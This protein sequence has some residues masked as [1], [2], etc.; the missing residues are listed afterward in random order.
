VIHVGHVAVP[1]MEIDILIRGPGQHAPE[2]FV[3]AMARG[4]MV[5]SAPDRM[6]MHPGIY[7]AA[8]TGQDDRKFEAGGFLATVRRVLVPGW[9]RQGP[10][11]PVCAGRYWVAG[12]GWRRGGRA[13]VCQVTMLEDVK[14]LLRERCEAT[15]FEITDPCLKPDPELTRTPLNRLP[16]NSSLVTYGPPDP[17]PSAWSIAEA[18]TRRETT[19]APP[20]G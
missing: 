2:R 17:I 12:R 8:W 14:A 20:D 16:S 11:I 4:F 3:C 19:R 13:F 6:R 9:R 5:D 18:A 7:K 1:H 15:D 10:A